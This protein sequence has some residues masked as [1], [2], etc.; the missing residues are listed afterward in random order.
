MKEAMAGA[1]ILSVGVGGAGPVQTAWAWG[2]EVERDSGV[3]RE[4]VAA[5]V[6]VQEDPQRLARERGPT[7]NDGDPKSRRTQYLP[8]SIRRQA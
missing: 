1:T 6:S 8:V 5:L 2:A 7:D 3:S 4:E